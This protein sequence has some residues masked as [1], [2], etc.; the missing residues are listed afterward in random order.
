MSDNSNSTVSA[1]VSL[2]PLDLAILDRI[3]TEQRIEKTSQAVRYALREHAR[4]QGW[5]LDDLV[6]E[7]LKAS[8]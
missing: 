6:A 5:N 3:Q 1:T 7:T 2:Y 4:L 8:A